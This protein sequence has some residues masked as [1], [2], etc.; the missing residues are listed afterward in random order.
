[1]REKRF[2]PT[3]KTFAKACVS[4]GD[5]QAFTTY[6]NPKGNADTKS[7]MRALKEELIWLRDWTTSHEQLKQALADWVEKYNEGYHHS[8]L[9]DKTPRQ[10]G[11]IINTAT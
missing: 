4:L 1:M 9:G 7:L 3:A 10:F 8:A 2:Q 11:K 6:N 5:T